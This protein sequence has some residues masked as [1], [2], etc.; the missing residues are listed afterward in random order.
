MGDQS[1]PIPALVPAHQECQPQERYGHEGMLV[2]KEKDRASGQGE[3][4]TSSLVM[5]GW[6]EEGLL[7]GS[8]KFILKG[9]AMREGEGPPT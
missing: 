6:L 9:C 2:Q 1:H 5:A 8:A 4:N 7:T 3:V